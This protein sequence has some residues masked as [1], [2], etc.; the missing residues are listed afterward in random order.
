MNDGDVEFAQPTSGVHG[1]PSQ[2][3]RP[4]G[5]QWSEE[6]AAWVKAQVCRFRGLAALDELARRDVKYLNMLRRAVVA[7]LR[8]AP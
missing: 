4:A 2:W 6:R 3:G 1:F 8:N 7:S 5:S